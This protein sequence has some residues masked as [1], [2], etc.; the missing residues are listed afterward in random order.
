MGLYDAFKDLLNVAQKADN[1]ELYRKLLDLS[2]QALELQDEIITLREE[3]RTLK[4]GKE[5]EERIIRHK[6]PY[7]TLL[8]D[9]QIIKYCAICW[10]NDQ[11]LVQMKENVD[12]PRYGKGINLYC[13]N[14]K[15]YCRLD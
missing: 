8:E 9:P 11:K 4:K 10:D 5:T 1:L 13:H 12:S 3:N 14:C 7:I 2:A 15:S 6:N